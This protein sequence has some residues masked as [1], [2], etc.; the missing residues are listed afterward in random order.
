[1]S[2]GASSSQPQRDQ[3]FTSE[4][5]QR[6][7]ERQSRRAQPGVFLLL[8]RLRSPLI[9]L[10]VVYAVAVL[11]FTL[12][13]GVDDQGRPWRMGFFHAFYFVSFLGTTIGLGEIPYAFNDAQ[14]MWALLSIYGTVVAWLYGIG[15]LLSTLQDPLFKR[16]VHENRVGNAVRRMREPFVLCCGYDDA[17]TLVTRELADHGIRSVVVDL[18]AERVDAVEV[19]ELRMA[20]PALRAD[21]IDPSALIRAGVT[22]PFCMATLALT[23]NDRTNLAI[24]LTAKLLN[25]TREVVCVAHKHLDQASMAKAGADHIINPHDTFADR[26]VVAMRA[27]SLH[28]IYEALTTQTANAMGT[29]LLVPRGRWLVCGYGRFGRTVRRQL[30]REDIEVTVVD[31]KAP[32]DEA[33]GIVNGSAADI[34]VLRQVKAEAAD[35]IVVATDNDTDNLAIA[36]MLRELNPAAFLVMR[37]NQRRNTP[38][39]RALAADIV[40]LSGHVVAA[41]VLR[42][43]RAPQ[44]SY[45]LKLAR[46]EDEAWAHGLL[47]RMRERIGHDTVEAWSLTIDAR[48]TPAVVGALHVRTCRDPGQPD[49]G[50]G[51]PQAAP[52]WPAAAAAAG[53]GR[54]DPAAGR[55]R[56]A[57]G[58]GPVADVRAR[59]G[60]RAPASRCHRRQRVRLPAHRIRV[61]PARALARGARQRGL[62]P[63]GAAQRG[64]HC[65]GSKPT[66]KRPC[67]STT[68]RLMTLGLASIRSRAPVADS[69]PSRAASS[70][71]RQVVPRRLISA[72]QPRSA[73]QASS[74]SGGTPAFLK[75]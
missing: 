29:P 51:Q 38:L 53:A 41:E 68:G 25:P 26:L 1:M 58:G 57:A 34:E 46:Q 52:A 54:Q 55:R 61:G 3:R 28:V 47:E 5:G 4:I 9:V 71:L 35:A 24:T 15:Q 59:G 65:A 74:L 43:I 67:Q 7:F 69:A 56:R 40:T 14:R 42:H 44:L 62:K 10:I 32:A 11:G 23:G 72:S 66:V 70:N 75:S 49:D 2:S 64:G 73:A 63:S 48:H 60:A 22:H 17:G 12:I 21:A 50:A 18:R 45:F 20:V 33:D 19:D 36:V 27:P 31:D 13:T 39:F 6:E 8:R 30:L 37:Q 16:I